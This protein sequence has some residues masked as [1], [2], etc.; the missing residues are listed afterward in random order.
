MR[1]HSSISHHLS[2]LLMM[3]QVEGPAT[4]GSKTNLNSIRIYNN[5]MLMLLTQPHECTQIGYRERQT[6][7]LDGVINDVRS[8]EFIVFFHALS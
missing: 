7:V 3:L 8:V 5:V 6:I 4:R 2:V 1:V